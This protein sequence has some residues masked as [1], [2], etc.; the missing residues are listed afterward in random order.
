MF[1]FLRTSVAVLVISLLPFAIAWTEEKAAE[2][3]R[4]DV[5]ANAL[6]LDT[7]SG[8]KVTSVLLIRHA[9]KATSPK[10]NPPLTIDGQ[11]RAAELIHVAE[12][13]EVKVI[14][15]TKFLRS[16]QTVQPISIR[17]NVP[18]TNYP[19][20]DFQALKNMVLPAYAGETVL[21]VGHSD[22]MGS[23]IQ[24]FGGDRQDCPPDNEYDNLCLVTI[25]GP[26]MAKVIN[27]QYGTQSPPPPSSP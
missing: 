11:A 24:T 6:A 2:I 9:E 25:Y 1:A 16:Q 20:N 10:E 12:K 4:S 14:Y 5:T 27:L 21:I 23:I 17:L 19:E 18:I 3:K 22:T 13:A 15:A 26:A 8:E 7:T